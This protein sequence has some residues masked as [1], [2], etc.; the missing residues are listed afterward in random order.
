M[1][2]GNDPFWRLR[3]KRVYVIGLGVSH[4]ELIP[5]LV[6]KGI[7]VTVCDKSEK[8]KAENEAFLKELGVK[9]LLGADYPES[10]C[11]AD[12]IFRTPGMYYY[13]PALTKARASGVVVTSETEMFF[14]N[15]PCP[16]YAVT[17]S[18]GKTTTTTLIYEM[19]KASG[20]TVHLGG[21]IGRPLYSRIE[22]VK[23]QDA[24]VVEL[25]SFQLLS[26]R[27]SPD[28]AVI[29][30]ISPNHLNV[31]KDMQ[32]YIDAK[33]NILW[34]QNAF[35]RAVLNR[36]DETIYNL[37][38]FVRGRLSLFSRRQKVE[39][40]AYLRK[41]GYLVRCEN[42]VEEV[43]LHQG[44]IRIPGIHN[45][46]NYLTA[47]AAVGNAVSK[48]AICKVAREFNGVEHRIEYVRTVNGV[49]Y[50]NDSI[51][52][53]PTRVIAGLRAFSQK[54]IVIAGGYDKNIPYEPL[55]K[56]VNERVK[57]L[58]L[59]GKTGP[60]I[61]KA[62]TSYPGYDPEKLRIVRVE[63]LEEAVEQARRLAVSGDIVTL[64]PAS[65]S[66]D[67]YRNFEERGQ[68]FK[69]LVMALSEEETKERGRKDE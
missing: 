6:E 58:I 31:H 43:L 26:M 66:F 69:R 50:Y 54:L 41:D 47:I 7:D 55:G 63:T 37:R 53:S 10:L 20:K 12:V 36:D 62:V 52:T 21:N 2:I 4:K 14:E 38:D 11:G 56:D 17:G 65:A 9:Y 5:L 44:E 23:E 16:I 59:L 1:L 67:L 13:D 68:H 29:T 46:E 61:E 8:Y 51:A 60:K 32:E 22:Q 39:T 33:C 35:S 28:V 30:N 57:L 64:S 34:H 15:C 49:K 42:G 25:S 18:D 45:V 27:S 19:L 3:G 24:A 48:E 40:G